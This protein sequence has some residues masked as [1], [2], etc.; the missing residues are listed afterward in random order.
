[1][2]RGPKLPL[3]K[4]LTL[5]RR[6][7]SQSVKELKNANSVDELLAKHAI[8]G[9]CLKCGRELMLVKN[10]NTC[11]SC[12]FFGKKFKKHSREGKCQKCGSE[13]LIDKKHN[14][15]FNCYLKNKRGGLK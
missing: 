5:L 12:S 3:T 7:I 15:C 2:R 13:G 10:T 4:K 9:K 1:M 11:V 6:T 14:E 8:K